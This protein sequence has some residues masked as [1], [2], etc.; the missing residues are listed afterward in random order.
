LALISIGYL[1]Y[2]IWQLATDAT[3]AVW[4]RFLLATLLVFFLLRGSRVAGIIW[5]ICN[6]LAALITAAATF[7][8]AQSDLTA[9]A[10]FAAITAVLLTHCGYLFFSPAVKQFQSPVPQSDG[11]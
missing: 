8:F 9:A 6:L 4:V 11:R 5:F 1:A 3:P 7:R 10:T 2:L